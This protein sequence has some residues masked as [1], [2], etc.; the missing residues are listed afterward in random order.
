MVVISG[1]STLMARA[2]HMVLTC[3]RCSDATPGDNGNRNC[4]AAA[5]A[6][7]ASFSTSAGL[8]ICG[9]G[10]AGGA[11]VGPGAAAAIGTDGGAAR[12]GLSAQQGD[13]V[14]WA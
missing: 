12:A 1:K 14:P 10:P 11:A 6:P 7:A 2:A 5:G 8:A 4:W 13:L 9:A 3:N